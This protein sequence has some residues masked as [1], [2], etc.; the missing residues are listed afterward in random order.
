VATD[1]LLS[2]GEYED[3]ADLQWYEE[4]TEEWVELIGDREMTETDLLRLGKVVGAL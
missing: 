3:E 4:Q 1:P 2:H